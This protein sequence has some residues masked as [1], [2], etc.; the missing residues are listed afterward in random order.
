MP[1]GMDDVERERWR[2]GVDKDLKR[3]EDDVKTLFRI[4]G[5]QMAD[6]Q[7]F[8]S[9]EFQDLKLLVN[10]ISTRLVVYSG[11]GAMIGGGL[12]SILVGWFLNHSK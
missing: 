7:D 8:K 2:G 11:L 4:S 3:N 10:T 12:M 9:K 1:V 6:F 5:Q